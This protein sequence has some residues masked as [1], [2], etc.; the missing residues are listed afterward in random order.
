VAAPFGL[1]EALRVAVEAVM[2]DAAF[3]TAVGGKG[4]VK[5]WIEPKPVPTEF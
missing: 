4:V 1:P 3:V 5:L 2:I